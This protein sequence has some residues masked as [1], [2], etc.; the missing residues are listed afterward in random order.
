MLAGAAGLSS[1]LLAPSLPAAEA[2]DGRHLFTLG[3]ASG[4][5]WP[6]SVVLWTRLAPDPTNGGGMPPQPVQVTWEL[7]SD[8]KMQQVVRRGTAMA[9]PNDA[10]SLHIEVDGLQPARTYWYRFRTRSEESIVG[11]TRTAPAPGVLAERLRFA[12]CCC[13]DYSHGY[14]T[15]HRDMANDDLDAVVFVGDYIYEGWPEAGWPRV[16]NNN[17]TQTLDDF[18]N[19]H[20]LYK[21]D[22]DLQANHA[23]HPFIITWDDHEVDNDYAGLRAGW[24]MDPQQFIERRTNSYKA[25]YEHMPLRRASI[26]SG[27]DLLLYRNVKFGR[28]AEFT[29]LDTRQYRDLQACQT[30]RSAGCTE[31]HSPARTI[32][33]VDQESWLFDQFRK[34]TGRWNFIAQQVPLLK[35]SLPSQRESMDKWDGYPASR[36]RLI[37]SLMDFK[38]SNPV[39]L[40]GDV[41]QAWAGEIKADFTR[42]DSAVVGTEFVCSSISSGSD[43]QRS[44]EVRQAVLNTNP[45][46]KYGN[47]KRGHTRFDL[48]PSGCRVDFRSPDYVSRP[49][50]PVRT[51][52][53][54]AMADGRPG[55]LQA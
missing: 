23:A 13:Q 12:L 43:G 48:T 50:A 40:S 32:M 34:S 14:Y 8:E 7:A 11:R 39:V 2:G 41:H 54:F 28:L 24:D 44:Q 18:R 33:G 17:D 9:M 29:V 31:H 46:V 20:A 47:G 19:R 53:S 16:H 37:Q 3:V 15:S 35:L 21:T 36:A 5:P 22:P 1:L 49:G 27:R 10:H 30:D 38:T 42:Q 25:Y 55:M 4:D 45:H 52:A 26:P 51:I 6:D